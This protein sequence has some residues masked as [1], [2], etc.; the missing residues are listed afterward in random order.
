MNDV[1]AAPTH[2]R[3][4]PR[5]AV[6]LLTLFPGG[7]GGGEVYAREVVGLLSRDPSLDVGVHLPRN[8]AGW[9]GGV[10]ERIA[11]ISSK[12]GMLPRLVAMAAAVLRS[13]ALRRT[14][15]GSDIVH[16]P[17][18]VPIPSASRRQRSIVTIADTQHLDLPELFH[19][20]ERMFRRFA[21]DRAARRADAVITVSEFTRSRLVHHLGIRPERITVAHL[22]VDQGE[23]APNLGERGDFL[24]YPARP[25]RHKN[26]ERLFEA[27]AI[28]R[29]RHPGLRLVLTGGG[30][31]AL[32]DVP[33]GVERAGHVTTAELGELY[34]SAAALVFP[35][36]YE[37]FGLPPL[38]AMAAGC[39][40]AASTAG[41]IPEIC[42]DAA[43]Y[44]DPED[45]VSIAEGIEQVL[46]DGPALS[47]RGVARAAGFTWANCA[48]SH[49]ALYAQLAG[50]TVAA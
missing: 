20:L 13:P 42:G 28:V 24:L 38:E 2:E 36:L 18:T 46:A 32:D 31:D 3:A 19:P 14:M 17:L 1:N 23:F 50:E 29:E 4:R 41:S 7:H 45:P 9:N 16:Y 49:R 8:A 37:G 40:V 34:R 30:L 48:A 39:P 33:P 25:W 6:S 27:F 12:G 11:P 44:F 47:G 26:H 22:G 21:Y 35:S 43:V 15:A 5:V 10:A